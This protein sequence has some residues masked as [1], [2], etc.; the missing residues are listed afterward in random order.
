MSLVQA[1]FGCDSGGPSKR[2]TTT[3]RKR[4]RG[5]RCPFHK[6]R[7][8]GQVCSNPGPS[9]PSHS[10]SL[11][12]SRQTSTLFNSGTKRSILAAKGSNSGSGKGGR[13]AGG[14]GNERLIDAGHQ[15]SSSSSDAPP[16]IVLRAPKVQAQK[17]LHG[18]PA[19]S[20][21]TRAHAAGV[22]L[23]P[24]EGTVLDEPRCPPPTAPSLTS[25]TAVAPPT[26]TEQQAAL[27]AKEK[28]VE[29]TSAVADLVVK[30]HPTPTAARNESA[31]ATA[32][33]TVSIASN[34]STCASAHE[35]CTSIGSDGHD[36]VGTS[37]LEASLRDNEEG[38]VLDCTPT[39][40]K[41]GDAVRSATLSRGT[42]VRAGY[43]GVGRKAAKGADGRISS[44]VPALHGE[45][46]LLDGCLHDHK[47]R[48]WVETT[49]VLAKKQQQRAA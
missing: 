9:F 23:A 30:T 41:P 17:R 28:A 47:V 7:R 24:T 15:G 20:F 48:T 46:M 35:T 3:S 27:G 12:T 14:S 1:R 18:K 42:F 21:F 16:A 43:K 26:P 37:V 38:T 34:V 4:A 10:S 29:C 13:N 40:T 45:L 36:T 44:R 19:S 22:T 33:S 5:D 6:F 11:S 49:L 31:D 25:A 8:V 32:V 39:R 2:V